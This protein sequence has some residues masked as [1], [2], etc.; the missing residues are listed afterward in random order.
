VQ[1]VCSIFGASLQ[2]DRRMDAAQLLHFRRIGECL[3]DA[4]RSDRKDTKF[5]VC[6]R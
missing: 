3:G 1:H 2:H 6:G 4:K 5:G